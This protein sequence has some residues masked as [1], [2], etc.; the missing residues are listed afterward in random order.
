[1]TEAEIGGDVVNTAPGELEAAVTGFLALVNGRKRARIDGSKNWEKK[2]ESQGGGARKES[3]WEKVGECSLPLSATSQQAVL[4]RYGCKR[5]EGTGKARYSIEHLTEL[6]V[7]QLF[8]SLGW[9]RE[10]WIAPGFQMRR[11]S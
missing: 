5:V 2:E 8:W 3:T 6:E 1:L 10:I 4:A 7:G 9:T 11:A